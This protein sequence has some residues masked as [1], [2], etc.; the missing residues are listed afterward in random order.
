MNNANGLVYEDEEYHLYYQY[1]PY[2][3]KWGICIG[4]IR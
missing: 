1:N 3:S 4:G 2:G